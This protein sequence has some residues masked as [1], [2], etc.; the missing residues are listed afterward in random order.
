MTKP[1]L[2]RYYNSELFIHNKKGLLK[3]TKQGFL[4]IW[5]GI[6]ESLI[7]KH[8]YKSINNTMVHLHMKRQGA[9]STRNTIPDTDLGEN[10]KTNISFCV[11]IYPNV[12]HEGE[13]YSDLCGRFPIM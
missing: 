3:A 13:I 10:I 2:S 6:T 8:L 4:K 12:P 5:P 7:K 11:T 9:S 1:E